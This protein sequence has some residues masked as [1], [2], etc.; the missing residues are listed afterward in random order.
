M[1]GPTSPRSERLPAATTTAGVRLRV[2][3]LDAMTA[4]YRDVLLLD[5]LDGDALPGEARAARGDEVVLGRR[6]GADA[7]AGSA[8]SGAARNGSPWAGDL[9]LVTLQHAPDLP[10][11]EP[12]GA[13]LF[14]TALLFPDHAA[15]AEALASVA[16]RAPH[17]YT[18]AGDHHVSQAFYL[19]D[20]EGNGVEL[21]V[22]RP[23]ETWLWNGGQVHMTTEYIDPRAFLATHLT[24]AARERLAGGPGEGAGVAAGHDGGAV[25]GTTV[26]HVH[27][28]V[29]GVPQARAFY[30]DAL[31]LD[32]TLDMGSALFV[33]AG[34][35][36]HHLAMN[37]WQSLGAGSRVPELG[38]GRVDLAVPGRADVEAA[39]A[40]LRSAGFQVRDDGLALEVDDPWGN[41]VRVA[42]GA[43]PGSMTAQARR[44]ETVR[45]S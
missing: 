28:R 34:G 37:T 21:Y 24:D 40:R 31:G 9:P 30:V 25:R 10:A 27:L 2:A 29:G 16:V 38:L 13:G 7:A 39:A 4:F 19:D 11:G 36:H 1:T 41:L 14:H 20:P 45:E 26:G 6:G 12:R 18:G 44:R 8:G 15:L 5:V 35:Y 3:D 32:A 23:R 42:P 43:W 33:S 22:D 17:L